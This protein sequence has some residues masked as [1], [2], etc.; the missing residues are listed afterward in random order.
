MTKWPSSPHRIGLQTTVGLCVCESKTKGV[1]M[2]EPALLYIL[3]KS[4]VG[5]E[6]GETAS[7]S[8]AHLFTH[9]LHDVYLTIFGQIAT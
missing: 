9:D 1:P 3:E 5:K 7:Y 4:L 6:G 8:Q 2:L